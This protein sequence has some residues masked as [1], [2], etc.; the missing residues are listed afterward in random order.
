MGTKKGTL[1]N[2]F[3]LLY[4]WLPAIESL[5]GEDVKALLLALVRYQRDRLPL[6]AFE[7]PQVDIYARMILPTITRRLVGQTGGIKAHDTAA[8]DTTVGTMVGTTV[9][10]TVPS[11]AEQS[12]AEQSKAEQSIPARSC[13][14]PI[15]GGAEMG[16]PAR[17]DP[18][19]GGRPAQKQKTNEHFERFWRSYPR[20]VGK[21]VAEKAF[22]KLSPSEELLETM[23]SAIERQRISEQW[24]RDNGQY[25]PH[26]A[27]WLN[28]RRW[29]DEE[30]HIDGKAPPGRRL[31]FSSFDADKFFRVALMKSDRDSDGCSA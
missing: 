7:N 12:I 8:V 16:S 31:E 29:E 14:E 23:L 22:A 17:E 26:P 6:P 21:A 30:V 11:I 5:Q 20:K 24:N 10:T 18:L 4:D 25:I 13:A 19:R 27:T 1:N 28:G 15:S 9:G 2:G 3:L